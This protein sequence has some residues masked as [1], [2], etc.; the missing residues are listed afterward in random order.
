[1]IAKI[2]NKGLLYIETR[3]D[4]NLFPSIKIADCSSVSCGEEHAIWITKNKD[5]FGIRSSYSGQ[6]GNKPDFY[7]KP[8]IIKIN[9][10]AINLSCGLWHSLILVE[11]Q[12]ARKMNTNNIERKIYSMGC[13]QNGRLGNSSFLDSFQQSLSTSISQNI[14]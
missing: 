8:I 11:T 6:L 2:N 5:I 4:C 1:M 12:V 7:E 10:T 3:G 13:G 14:L 9:E